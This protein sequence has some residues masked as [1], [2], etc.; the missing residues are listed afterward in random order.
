MDRRIGAEG[1][2]NQTSMMTSWAQGDLR[3]AE[4]LD[5][6][7]GR[8]GIENCSHHPLDVTHRDDESQVRQPNAAWVLGIFRRLSKACK[9]VR[10]KGRAKRETTSRAWTEEN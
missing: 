7:Q 4:W 1:K 8:W 3:D 2:L 9:Q 5:F 10:A 6:E